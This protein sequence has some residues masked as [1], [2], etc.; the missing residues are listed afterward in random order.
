MNPV[1]HFIRLLL[2][3]IGILILIAILG[4]CYSM[5]FD[6]R[7]N[8]KTNTLPNFLIFVLFVAGYMLPAINAIRISHPNYLIIMILNVVLAW[9]GIGWLL[10]M[11]WS[12]YPPRHPETTR[13]PA[14]KSLKQQLLEV[15]GLRRNK[16]LSEDEARSHRARLL[17]GLA[18]GSLA[19][20]LKE[21]RSLRDTLVIT[22]PEHDEARH[23]LV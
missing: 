11:I 15:E 2:I 4:L 13:V 8:G 6:S 16:L 20:R 23:L 10:V 3:F 17:G 5:Y 21:L 12:C 14:T 9:T 19:D 7:N 22:I 1:N 18:G